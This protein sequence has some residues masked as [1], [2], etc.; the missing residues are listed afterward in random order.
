MPVAD[1]FNPLEL[2]A[3]LGPVR[4]GADVKMVCQE[5]ALHALRG[6][7]LQRADS[8]WIQRFEEIALSERGMDKDSGSDDAC[9]SSRALRPQHPEAAPTVS[10]DPALRISQRDFHHVIDKLTLH[11]DPDLLSRFENFTARYGTNPDFPLKV[12]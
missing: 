9:D 5:A 4:V 12:G 1:D 6:S 10:S 3:R 2:E 7:K 11:T 8:C